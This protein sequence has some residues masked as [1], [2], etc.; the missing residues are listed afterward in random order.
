M[1]YVITLFKNRFSFIIYI[2]NVVITVICGRNCSGD[3]VDVL[4]P[5]S[6]DN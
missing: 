6:D 1:I 4:V 5:P 2:P 3:G